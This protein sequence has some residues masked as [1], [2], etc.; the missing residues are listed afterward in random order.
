MKKFFN[1]FI[2]KGYQKG[3]TCPLSIERK[4]KKDSDKIY[5]M[6]SIPMKQEK[7]NFRRYKK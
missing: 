5:K 2:Q 6:F 7:Q 4:N 1:F 3:K